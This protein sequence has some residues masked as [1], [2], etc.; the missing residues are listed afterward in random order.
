MNERS[1]IVL[2][3]SDGPSTRAVYGALK[4]K[5]F[6]VQVVI[7]QPVSKMQMTRRRL[8]K[9]GFF[10]VA[11]QVLFIVLIVP[12][13]HRLGRRRIEEINQTFGLSQD[14]DPADLHRVDSVNSP[15]T[16]ELLTKLAPD[17]VVVNGTRIIGRQTR[18]SVTAAFINM[19]AGITPAYRGVHGGYWALADGRPE[20]IGTTVH[21]VD[22][23]IDTGKIIE[24]AFFEISDSDNFATYPLLHTAHGIPILIDAV[25]RA[26]NGSMNVK[27]A[28]PGLESKLRYHPTIW[29]YL[30]YRFV[31][32]VR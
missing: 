21:F 28:L 2:L 5:F 24:Q 13:L 11:G 9:L 10:A 1:R 12:L 8:K 19:H 31:G 18:Q 30:R 27:D 32:G 14:L 3:C 25:E 20:L 26:L 16:R 15:Q 6:D 23:G 17:V 29:Q 7:E 22:D 4:R